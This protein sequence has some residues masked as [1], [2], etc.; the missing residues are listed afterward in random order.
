MIA[1]ATSVTSMTSQIYMIKVMMSTLLFWVNP[2][3]KV[4]RKIR[5]QAVGNRKR[6]K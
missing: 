5:N 2:Y 3:Q 6:K 4:R 1:I